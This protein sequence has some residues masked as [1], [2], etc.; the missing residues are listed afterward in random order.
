MTNH[1]TKLTFQLLPLR[2]TQIEPHCFNVSGIPY[3]C[4]YARGVGQCAVSYGSPL[5]LYWDAYADPS[6]AAHKVH[7]PIKS[8]IVDRQF[9]LLAIFLRSGTTHGDS[10]V[11]G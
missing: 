2:P 5:E 9:N 7:L 11:H 3:L 10:V 8:W 1:L 6:R 4:C